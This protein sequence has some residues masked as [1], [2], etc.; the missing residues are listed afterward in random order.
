M[1]SELASLDFK[2]ALYS[3]DT[4]IYNGNFRNILNNKQ[5]LINNIE[6][7]RNESKAFQ[8]Y[9]WISENGLDQSLIMDKTFS[10][11]ILV[12]GNQKKGNDL[13]TKVIKDNN[14]PIVTATPHFNN[15][16]TTDEGLIRDYDEDGETYYFRGAVK[17]N[18]VK[19]GNW[20]NND[21]TGMYV[22]N[23]KGINNST[24]ES[25]VTFTPAEN[26]HLTFDYQVSSQ[27]NYDKLTITLN[28]GSNTNTLVNEI[29]GENSGSINQE[30]IANTTYTLTFKYTKDV[31]NASGQDRGIIKNLSITSIDNPQV[32]TTSNYGF[33]KGKIEYKLWRIV[34]IN[35][36]N[37]IRLI[38]NDTEGTSTFNTNYRNEKY[39]GY[40]YDNSGA[41]KQDGTPSTIKTYIDNWYNENMASTT[42]SSKNFDNLIANTRFCNDT[43]GASISGNIIYGA[44]DRLITNKIPS[45][46]CPNTT[47]TYGGEYDLKVGLLNADEASFAGGRHGSSNTKY[48]LNKNRTY[49][50]LSPGVYYRGGWGDGYYLDETGQNVIRRIDEKR[51][52]FPVISLR[53]D[54]LFTSGD[55]TIDNPYIVSK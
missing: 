8:L 45:Y 16:A 42:D 11:K 41:N 12:N 18:Y 38:D 15:I 19:L 23:N 47:K 36:D 34:R 20:I 29:S 21:Y 6:L 40:T 44:Y 46:K 39:L 53:S 7:N 33:E 54:I 10:M 2:W 51:D 35:G 9:I 27:S 25:T 5:L 3:G 49:W 50:F 1:D 48:Y 17:D 52:V 26:G 31:S 4:K 14:S 13:L 43:T 24:A 37:T 30:I 32:L 28:D 22:S 55:G